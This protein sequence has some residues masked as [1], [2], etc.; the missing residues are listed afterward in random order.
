MER[1]KIAPVIHPLILPVSKQILHLGVP[2]LSKLAGHYFKNI[3]PDVSFNQKSLQ[4]FKINITSD[5]FDFSD[6]HLRFQQNNNLL[7]IF[8]PNVQ[9][10]TNLTFPVKLPT[11][12][13]IFQN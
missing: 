11:L 7:K 8:V 12:G 3:I 1:P 4:T 9:N 6:F 10:L 13:T 2:I 5:N